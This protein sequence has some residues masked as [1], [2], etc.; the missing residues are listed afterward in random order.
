MLLEYQCECGNKVELIVKDN[1]VSVKCEKCG[2][3]M[4]KQLAVP[5]FVLKGTCWERDGY[6]YTRS[7]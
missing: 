2:R 5:A 3:K 1:T 7:K 6:N 4:E